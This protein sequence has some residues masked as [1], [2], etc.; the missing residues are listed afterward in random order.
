MFVFFLSFVL[1]YYMLKFGVKVFLW[2]RNVNVGKI[3]DGKLK[4]RENEVVK[5]ILRL[6]VF[7]RKFLKI[8]ICLYLI[9]V[10]A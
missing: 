9:V 4:V 3:D 6:F 1:F 10:E 5:D 2:I 7:E 8:L